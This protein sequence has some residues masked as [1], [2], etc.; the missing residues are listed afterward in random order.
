MPGHIYTVEE[1]M[2]DDSFIDYC[3]S[4]GTAIP[5]RW[6]TIIRENPGQEK[7]FEEAKRLVLAMHG[8]LSKPEINRQI[9]IVRRQIEG[10]KEKKGVVLKDGPA[11]STAFVI[12]GKGQ[13]KRRLLR[14]AVYSAVGLCIVTAGILWW[15]VSK[16][17]NNTSLAASQIAPVQ[18]YHSP[19]GDRR[20][21]NLPDGSMVILNSNSSINFSFTRDKREVQLKGDAFFRVAKDPSKPFTVYANNIAA[22]ALGTEFYMRGHGDSM[23]VDLL[24][25][26]LRVVTTSNNA[27]AREIILNSGESGKYASNLL[28]KK[29]SFDTL[30]LRSWLAGSIDFKNIPLQ[31]VVR[32]LESWYG[33]QIELARM[34]LK[35]RLI[36]AN[37]TND[38]LQ[39]VL[40]IICFSINSQ[41]V[42]EDNKVI[43]K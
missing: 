3:L 1:L 13:I 24:E 2:L 40:K 38:S 36:T 4:K 6:R 10:D 9:E 35:S 12:T 34:D 20:K 19:L 11:L 5:S 27:A 29:S 14:T 23:Q 30:Y 39:D 26:K 25:G 22:T 33:I 43:I 7:T 17:V 28:L 32:Q 31:K 21:I 41:Y 8:G 18:E 15:V 37:F 16:P 42:I